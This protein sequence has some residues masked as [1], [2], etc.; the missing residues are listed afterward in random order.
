[1]KGNFMDR[2]GHCLCDLCEVIWGV[3][4]F[5]FVSVD[6]LILFRVLEF[7]NRGLHEAQT[8]VV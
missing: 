5:Y 8:A 2:K 3:S 1:M 6:Q 4:A 7:N